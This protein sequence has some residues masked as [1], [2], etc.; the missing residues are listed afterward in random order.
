MSL[1]WLKKKWWME[2]DSKEHLKQWQKK[3]ENKPGKKNIKNT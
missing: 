1:V 3:H 2:N